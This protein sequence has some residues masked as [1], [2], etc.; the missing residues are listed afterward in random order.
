[1]R[2]YR[3]RLDDEMRS[4]IERLKDLPDEERVGVATELEG[5][6]NKKH[7]PTT[8]TYLVQSMHMY[9][10]GK[11]KNIDKRLSKMRTDN[12]FGITLICASNQVDE[13]FLHEKMAEFRREGEW[14]ELPPEKVM[15]IKGWMG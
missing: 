4:F 8:Y 1:M 11:T 14:F 7:K 5:Y 9:K 2:E 13:D 3:P 10:I 12:P 6:L 15:F